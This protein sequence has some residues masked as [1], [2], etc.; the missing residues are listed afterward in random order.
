MRRA[1]AIAALALS[2]MLC[3]SCSGGGGGSR[4]SDRDQRFTRNLRP[5]AQP[6]EV[7]AAE[8][9]FARTAQ[10][11]GQWTAFAEYATKDAVM[12][13]PEAVNAQ[14]WLKGRTNPAQ[15]VKWQP[16]QVWSSCDGSLAVTK[17]AWQRPDGS[18]GYFTTVWQRQEDGAYKWVMDQGDALAEPL[19]EPD[20]VQADV[21]D[22]PAARGGQPRDG[23][24]R[25]Q[26]AV[27]AADGLSGSAAD[28]SLTWQM[29]MAPD[30][31]RTLRVSVRRGEG[32]EQVLT[33][34]VAAPAG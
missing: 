30:L 2:A 23:N 34:I 7:V 21:A 10:E 5:V 24:R 14:Q 8:I 3:V 16:Y 33:S 29:A 20:M 13:V 15:A 19:E 26:P 17:G 31:A 4:L 25:F 1:A 18:V 28:G 27:M 32:M 12:F 9:A 11:K 22:C 6:G